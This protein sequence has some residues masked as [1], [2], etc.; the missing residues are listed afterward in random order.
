MKINTGPWVD[1]DEFFGRER[2]LKNL[3]AVMQNKR[4]SVFIPGPRRIGKTSL[5]KEFIRRNKDKYK[6]IYLDLE[7]RHSI[8]ELCGDLIKEI[9][10]NHSGLIKSKLKFAGLWNKLAEMVPK[11]SISGIVDIETGKISIEAK[12]TLDM[13]EAVFEELHKQDFIFA[14]DEFADF[15]IDIKKKGIEEV[16]FFLSWLRGLRQEQKIRLI[17]TGSINI[18]SAIEELNVSDLMNDLVDIEIFPLNKDEIKT[19]LQQLSGETNITLTEDAM[20]FA[21]ERLS[22]GIPFFVQL[23]ASGLAVY[24][25]AKEM[26]YDT[27]GLKEIYY[28]ITGRQHK[29]FIDL[30]S[31]LKEHLLPDR[32]KAAKTILAHLASDPMTFD[33]LWPFVEDILTEKKSLHTILKR[34]SDES[35]ILHEKR[36]YRFVS[37]MLADWWN[38]SYDWEKE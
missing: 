20:E 7:R 16:Q 18:I 12:E 24:K 22:D 19:L 21:V 28:K 6:F 2:E 8:T 10:K 26:V 15:L 37:P 38:N 36:Y 23:F 30:H 34:L 9:E 11:L 13:M 17:I 5:V 3:A 14:F 35:Y 33:D 29:E 32:F 1:G 27:P 25:E 31:R 4:A